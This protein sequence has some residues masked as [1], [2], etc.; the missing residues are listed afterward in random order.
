MA[1]SRGRSYE[2]E[3]SLLPETYS[4]ALSTDVSAL[5]RFVRRLG[6]RPSYFVGSGGAFAVARLAADSYERAYRVPSRACTPLE[7]SALAPT[8]DSGALLFSASG[9]NKDSLATLRRAQA[10]AFDPV[11]VVTMRKAPIEL[12][13]GRPVQQIALDAPPLKD[14]FLATNSVLFMATA[15]MRSIGLGDKLAVALPPASGAERLLRDRCL[16]LTAPG[17]GS[18]ATDLETRLAELGLATA[19]VVDYRNFAHG[20]HFG[21]SHNLDATTVIALLSPPYDRIAKRTL[22][23]LPDGADIVRLTTNSDW[24]MSAIAL[25]HQSMRLILGSAR[26]R[27]IKVSRPGV[28]PFGRQLYHLNYLKLLP[29]EQ[30]GPV[31]K[32]LAAAGLREGDERARSVVQAGLDK[33]LVAIQASDFDSLILDYDGTLCSTDERTELP[34]EKLRE[35][36]I[37]ILDKGIGLAFATGR[38]DSLWETLRQWVPESLWN[39]VV[40]GLYH[41]AVV[42]TL[43]DEIDLS[44]PPGDEPARV[45]DFV[46]SDPF[47][48]DCTFKVTQYQVRI[49]P[50][51]R[52]LASLSRLQTHVSTLLAAHGECSWRALASGHSIDVVPKAESKAGAIGALGRRGF[53]RPLLIG[54]QGHFGGNDFDLLAASTYSL[55]VDRCSSDLSRCWNLGVG[56]QSGPSLLCRYL[57]ALRLRRGTF[58][59]NWTTGKR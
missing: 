26:D 16:I 52:S 42:V 11:C 44:G 40:L 10:G 9:R 37:K 14:G 56:G 30:N 19:Q 22:D 25:L 41:A 36:L 45:A 21:F 5:E 35:K 38:G 20:R 48:A 58:R 17:L 47:T 1:T 54:D 6:G 31:E 23:L 2:E 27:S 50:G 3:L 39:H 24:P 8:T 51:K 57:A 7:F 49:E 46:K 4:A 29:E 12:P 13:R 32:K 55:S 34:S 53:E 18:V 43:A 33:W 15:W 59:F 28:P